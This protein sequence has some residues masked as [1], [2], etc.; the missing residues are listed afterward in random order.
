[1]QNNR[2]MAKITPKNVI[3]QTEKRQCFQKHTQSTHKKFTMKLACHYTIITDTV[4]VVCTHFA[5]F[6]C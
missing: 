5:Y 2:L 1:M 3:E 4:L 6:F